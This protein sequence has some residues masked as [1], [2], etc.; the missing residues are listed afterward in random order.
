M[1]DGVVKEGVND[2]EQRQVLEGDAAAVE[3]T[4]HL[5][6]CKSQCK[7]QSKGASARVYVRELTFK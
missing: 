4:A 5:H 6:T 1:R 2:P 3:L 7:A